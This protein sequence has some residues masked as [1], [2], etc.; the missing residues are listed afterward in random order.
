MTYYV[1]PNVAVPPTKAELPA[2][3]TEQIK[4][5]VST[6]QNAENNFPTARTDERLHTVQFR[7]HDVEKLNLSHLNGY[8]VDFQIPYCKT[9]YKVVNSSSQAAHFLLTSTIDSFQ[10]F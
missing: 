8:P 3:K 10:P 2:L 5:E 4:S 1:F 7:F 9:Q 6:Y